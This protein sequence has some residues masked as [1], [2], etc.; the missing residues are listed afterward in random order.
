VSPIG[1][2]VKKKD[3]VVEGVKDGIETVEKGV[4]KAAE[5]AGQLADEAEKAKNFVKDGYY[6]KDDQVKDARAKDEYDKRK[7]A[8]ET[9]SYKERDNYYNLKEKLGLPFTQEEI[10]DRI[11]ARSEIIADMQKQALDKYLSGNV[12]AIGPILAELAQYDPAAA[13]AMQEHIG[14]LWVAESNRLEIAK[15]EGNLLKEAGPLIYR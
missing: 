13:Q 10:N 3:Q 15:Y 11:G 8:G 5:I 6:V 12:K 7:A 4:D 2:F 1:T 9:L 14:K